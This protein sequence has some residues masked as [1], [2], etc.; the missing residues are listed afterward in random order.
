MYH[1]SYG[2]NYPEPFL[3]SQGSSGIGCPVGTI[4]WWYSN[5]IPD[6]YLLCNGQS[7]AAYPKLN[8][9]IGA[10]VPNL[11]GKFIYAAGDDEAL[12]TIAQNSSFKMSFDGNFPHIY[13]GAHDPDDGHLSGYLATPVS[14]ADGHAVNAIVIG[15]RTFYGEYK[16]MHIAC[17]PIIKAK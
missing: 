1:I 13:I 2:R 17:Y 10:N 11:L 16:P 12:G 7:T 4:L 9:V 6:G 5:I 3:S 15:N 14:G 8:K